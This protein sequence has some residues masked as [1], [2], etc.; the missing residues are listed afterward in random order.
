MV[1]FNNTRSTQG[2]WD[3]DHERSIYN[4]SSTPFPGI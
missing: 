3:N 4:D 1:E 2:T